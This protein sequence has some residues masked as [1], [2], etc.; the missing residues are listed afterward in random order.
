M[1]AML[2]VF[3]PEGTVGFARKS[4]ILLNSGRLLA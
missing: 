3:L 4:L 2:K 1:W